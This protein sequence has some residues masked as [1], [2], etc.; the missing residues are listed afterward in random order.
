VGQIVFLKGSAASVPTPS[1]GKVTLFVDSSDGVAKLKDDEGN[2]GDL[3]GGEVIADAM[4]FKGAIDCSA[5]PNYP[6]ADAGHLYRVSV[7]GKIGGASGAVVEVGD[8]LLCNTDGSSAGTQ[9]AVGA[10]W[11]VIQTN[12]DGAVVG[13]SSATS[14]DVATFNGSSGKIVQDSGKSFSTD[15]TLA[16]NSDELIPTEKAVKGF[17]DTATGLLVPKALVDAKGDLLVGTAADTVDRIAA[18]SNGQ[19]LTADSGA[20]TGVKWATPEASSGGGPPAARFVTTAALAANTRTGNV[21]EANANGALSV[22]G[23]SPTE[24]ELVLVKNEA[25]GANNGLFKVLSP[26]AAG[27]KWKLERASAMDASAELVPGML[28]TVAEGT[29]NEDST[30]RL[31]TNGPITLNTTT[32]SFAPATGPRIGCSVRLTAA[33]NVLN[34]TGTPIPWD[35]AGGTQGYNVGGCWSSGQPTRFVMPIPGVY[36]LS[37]SVWR[38]DENNAEC[39]WALRFNWEGV[40][41]QGIASVNHHM[42]NTN[43]RLI[44]LSHLIR[45][46]VAGQFVT[47]EVFQDSG[48]TRKIMADK[49]GTDFDVGRA[50]FELIR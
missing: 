31:T 27:S 47:A 13:P 12:I 50:T 23:G 8:T 6:A 18:G 28:I 26:G 19:V 42:L 17:V 38:D 29:V 37:V 9:A 45:C 46:T 32:L 16:G 36:V 39:E 14:G 5:N 10:K 35:D 49:F 3:G 21:L 2:V 41:N 44:H 22:D 4:V 33:K 30:W 34:T 20:A 40:A 24:N 7:A 15:N 1:E 48:G 43:G 25:T 11:N